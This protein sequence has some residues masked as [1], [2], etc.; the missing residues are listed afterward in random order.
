MNWKPSSIRST[1]T[2]PLTFER[3]GHGIASIA[4]T[5]CFPSTPKIS[6]FAAAGLFL[7]TAGIPAGEGVR[8]HLQKHIPIAAGLGG[9]SG[10]AAT[11]LLAMNELFGHPLPPS[12]LRNSP[13]PWVP[14]SPSFSKTVPPWPQDGGEL[15]TPLDFFPALTGAWIAAGPSRLWHLDPVGLRT[16]GPLSR[17]LHGTPGRART[18]HFPPANRT[19][20]AAGKEFYNSLEAPALLQIPAAPAVPGILPRTRRPAA[21]MSGSGSSTFALAGARASAETLLEQ[22]KA[23][24]GPQFWTALVKLP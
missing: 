11:T 3:R 10:N 20:S 12:K 23:K 5:P 17:R 24:F 18:P 4:A 2:I 8:I 21:F 1:S 6:S 19:L 16:T 13:P 7:N 9:G 15:I 14:T 22:F